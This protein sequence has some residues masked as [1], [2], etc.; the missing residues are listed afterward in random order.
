MKYE[1][2][3]A[4][5]AGPMMVFLSGFGISKYSWMKNPHTVYILFAEDEVKYF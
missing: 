3:L 5:I 1:N 2:R 4:I